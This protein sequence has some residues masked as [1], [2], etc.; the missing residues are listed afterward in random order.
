MSSSPSPHTIELANQLHAFIESGH[1]YVTDINDQTRR[2]ITRLT[3]RTRPGTYSVLALRGRNLRG[4][5][6]PLPASFP[7]EW[8]TSRRQLRT[9]LGHFAASMTS[10]ESSPESDTTASSSFTPIS[11][12]PE[13]SSS[14][15]HPTPLESTS[16][17]MAAFSEA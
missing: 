8:S 5:A 2:V 7:I 3:T 6:E 11:I 14:S 16:S 9:A 10:L 4:S 1:A 13:S 15:R 12:F 17:N